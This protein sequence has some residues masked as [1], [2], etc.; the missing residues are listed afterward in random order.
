MGS[1]VLRVARGGSGA[2][3][4]PLAARPTQDPYSR[5]LSQ[6][7][8]H[9]P[10]VSAE[11]RWKYAPIPT[12]SATVRKRHSQIFHAH[13]SFTKL[14][15]GRS[16]IRDRPSQVAFCSTCGRCKSEKYKKNG[17]KKGTNLPGLVVNMWRAAARG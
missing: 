3:A 10:P 12:F 4:P 14:I 1:G 6:P 15:F 9:I 5:L 16:G 2:K 7:F 8:N 13:K 11:A 17:G